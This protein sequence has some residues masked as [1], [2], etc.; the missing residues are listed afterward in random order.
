[1][2]ETSSSSRAQQRMQGT[3][4]ST[5][6]SA[7]TG[8]DGN[9]GSSGGF[10]VDERMIL[11]EKRLNPA[12]FGGRVLQSLPTPLANRFGRKR[13][14]ADG[15]LEGAAENA[16]AK[17]ANAVEGGEGA[18]R[19]DAPDQPPKAG[20]EAPP[21]DRAAPARDGGRATD[22]HD[23]IESAGSS[24]LGAEV[25]T[26]PRREEQREAQRQ[27]AEEQEQERT[28]PSA[29]RRAAR[30]GVDG[31][32]D[33][34]AQSVPGA[35]EAGE[36]SPNDSVPSLTDRDST[37]GSGNSNGSSSQRS[38]GSGSGSGAGGDNAE[39]RR[40]RRPSAQ[41]SSQQRKRRRSRMPHADDNNGMTLR[42]FLAKTADKA[43][44]TPTGSARN[45]AF[46]CDTLP[47]EDEDEELD[48][49]GAA[50]REPHRCC[51]PMA[52]ERDELRAQVSQLSQHLDELRSVANELESV[53][54]KL[55]S[56]ERDKSTLSSALVKQVRELALQQRE[57]AA[58][59]C[60]AQCDR[61][62]RVTVAR[63][64]T[65]L[66]EVWEDGAELRSVAERLNNVAAE[67][68][69]I[70]R[71]RKELAK[72]RKAPAPAG[73]MPPP[74]PPATA[75]YVQ[76]QEEI[77]KL[78]M[79]AL[80][81]DEA[82]L[83]EERQRL[84]SEKAL[85]MRE[86]RRARDENASR[87]KECR[88][89][90]ERY[91]P[92]QLLGRGGFSE[93]WK[94]YDLRAARYVACKV[95]QLHAHWS[96]ARKS[97]YIRHATR[98]YKIHSALVHPRVVR[99]HDVFEIDESSFCTVLEYCG[100]GC[101]LDSYLKLHR[102]LPER[103]AKSVMAQMLSGLL[104]LNLQPRRI[105][106]YDLKPGNVLY[107]RGEARITDFGLSKIMEED[108]NTIDGMELTSQGAGTYWYLPPECFEVGQQ[109]PRISSKVDVW[110]CGV[111]MYQML[112]G[113]KPFG[114]DMSQERMLRDQTI[115][116]SAAV[117]FPAKPSVSQEAKDFVRL[118]LT[119]DQAD[120]PDIRTLAQHPYIR[121]RSP[122][123]TPTTTTMTTTTAS[124]K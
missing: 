97:N 34:P 99:L 14:T 22:G 68:E 45:A 124:G 27:Q 43:A 109:A 103:E 7:H 85:L 70:E 79:Q 32:D 100:D 30:F 115:L 84:E 98:E 12:A 60:A 58:R 113:R 118:C 92:M 74:Q 78:R 3:M 28:P 66:Q 31:S 2:E 16:G 73:D 55:S 44:A 121:G 50:G 63:T 54:R 72:T 77:F 38:G 24:S 52:A 89:L 94:A 37:R 104:Y 95:H 69:S 81:R 41:N 10:A 48:A 80:R 105:I 120:R 61:L 122:P 56:A 59:R 11:L 116:K 82:A 57:T 93:V 90:N 76:E 42:R 62:G 91:V 67:R 96:E 75:H 9:G 4:V 40:P 102:T 108:A 1:M 53:Q 13:T 88:A 20:T 21:T 15:P 71:A 23:S 49:K 119:R 51:A 106:H 18:E 123:P 64:G 83:L 19:E 107:H 47:D 86:L 39:R 33:A 17:S 111:I 117:E 36:Q 29:K 26:S 87:F 25:R 46:E 65:S 6:A 8:G 35:R 112:F 5:A 114:H 110:S 101:D